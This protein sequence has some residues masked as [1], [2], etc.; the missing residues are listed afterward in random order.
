MDE[1]VQFCVDDANYHLERAREILT[2][3]IKNPAKYHAE[4]LDYYKLMAKAF[5]ILVWMSHNESHTHE[6][7]PGDSLSRAH[8]SSLSSEDNFEPE[9]PKLP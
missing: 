6:N 3:E 8:S 7:S 5:P 1:H 2:K 4:T 9:S